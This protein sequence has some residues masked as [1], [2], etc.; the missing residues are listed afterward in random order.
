MKRPVMM[1]LRKR[2]RL[3]L[4]AG[5]VAVLAVAAFLNPTVKNHREAVQSYEVKMHPDSLVPYVADIPER[6]TYHNCIIFSV[7]TDPG[8]KG[9]FGAPVRSIGFWG[10]VLFIPEP[11]GYG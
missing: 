1:K 10:K 7:T 9:L 4:L 2:K 11:K 3:T 8:D 6:L 5:S